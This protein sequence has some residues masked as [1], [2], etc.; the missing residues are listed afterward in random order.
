MLWDKLNLQKMPSHL[1]EGI[2]II[3][4]KTYAVKKAQQN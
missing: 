3:V 4:F 2:Q 1:G